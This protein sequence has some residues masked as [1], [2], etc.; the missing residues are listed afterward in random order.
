MRKSATATAAATAAKK[1]FVINFLPFFLLRAATTG[2]V[3][4]VMTHKQRWRYEE[5]EREREIRVASIS[6]ASPIKVKSRHFKNVYC[7]ILARIL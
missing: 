7:A 5:R 2:K 3:G 4:G 6:A 1:K